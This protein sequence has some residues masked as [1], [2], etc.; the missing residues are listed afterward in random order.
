M[1]YGQNRA[2]P[3]LVNTVYPMSKERFTVIIKIVMSEQLCNT[4][5]FQLV[6]CLGEGNTMRKSCLY[7]DLK[8][9]ETSISAEIFKQQE[10]KD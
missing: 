10:G 3:P 2:F 4:V 6:T 7:L 1:Y 8:T 5:Q 9:T